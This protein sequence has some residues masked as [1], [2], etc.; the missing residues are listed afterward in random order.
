MPNYAV[1]KHCSDSDDGTIGVDYDK[2]PALYESLRQAEA[3][4]GDDVRIAVKWDKIKTGW[5]R[6]YDRCYGPNFMMQISG[7]GLVAPCGMKFNEKHRALHIGSIVR[8]RFRDIWE[9]ER[10]TEVMGYLGS[11]HFNPQERCGS[12]CLQHCTNEWLYEHVNGRVELPL[13]S[14][15]PHLEFI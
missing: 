2:Y 11:E 4:G 13:A 10:W 6:S 15:P 3:I 12:L 9:S 8:Q 5:N 1:I 14:A 7:N